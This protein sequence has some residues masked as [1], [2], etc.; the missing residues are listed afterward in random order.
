MCATRAVLVLLFAVI[1]C[2]VAIPAAMPQPASP[3]A[4]VGV[5]PR[6]LEKRQIDTLETGA[7]AG[8]VAEQGQDL[9]GS[10]SYGYGF[11]GGYPY[12]GYGHRPYYGGYGY[13]F[14]GGYGG[15]GYA[16]FYPGYGYGYYGGFY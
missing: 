8:A 5:A 14:Y 16:P 7:G 10:S 6:G 12:G 1:A 11:Y 2:A 13:P 15:Y 4:P 3:G 9:K